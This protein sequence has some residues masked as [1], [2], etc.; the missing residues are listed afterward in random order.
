MFSL[1]TLGE[2]TTTADFSDP[3]NPVYML[4]VPAVE[5]FSLGEATI[6]YGQAEE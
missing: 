4:E 1:D 2:L 3:A 6:G 5:A